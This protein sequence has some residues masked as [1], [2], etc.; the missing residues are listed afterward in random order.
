MHPPGAAPRAA[1]RFVGRLTD[2]AAGNGA[3]VVVPGSH[4][5]QDRTRRPEE[6]Q[7]VIAEMPAGSAVFYLGSTLH[8]RGANTTAIN[9]V[10]ACK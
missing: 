3:T 9:G 8:A 10:A 6:H 7:F 5:W 4:R 2:F 1:A